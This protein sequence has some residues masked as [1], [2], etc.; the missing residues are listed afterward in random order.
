MGEIVL[1]N[2]FLSLPIGIALLVARVLAV[3][4]A[5]GPPSPFCFPILVWRNSKELVVRDYIH[6]LHAHPQSSSPRLEGLKSFYPYLSPPRLI[7]FQI[8]SA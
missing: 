1:P 8:P 5:C 7:Y 3:D 6:N 2:S 4:A